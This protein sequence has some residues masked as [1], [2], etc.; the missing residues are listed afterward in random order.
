MPEAESSLLRADMRR[1]HDQ[2]G[3]LP[4]DDPAGAMCHA[5]NYEEQRAVELAVIEDLRQPPG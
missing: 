4:S 1:D 3:T 5:A 2:I